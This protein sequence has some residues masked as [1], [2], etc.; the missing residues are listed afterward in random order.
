M[1]VIILA[2]FIGIIFLFYNTIIN[3]IYYFNNNYH[4]KNKYILIWFYSMLII[5]IILFV[6]IQI[7]KYMIFDV[8]GRIGMEGEIGDVGEDGV[9]CI[10]CDDHYRKQP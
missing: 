10:I 4:I 5:N 8:R 9:G 7:Y 6:S 1:Y 2:V 3:T